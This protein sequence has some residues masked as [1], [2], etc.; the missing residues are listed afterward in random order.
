MQQLDA[1]ILPQKWAN[2]KEKR[3]VHYSPWLT[4]NVLEAE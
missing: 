2:V 4:R 1:S 3:A